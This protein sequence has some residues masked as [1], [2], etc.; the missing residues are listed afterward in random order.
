MNVWFLATM[1]DS[2]ETP[3]NRN[4]ASN[5][6]RKV[7]FQDTSCNFMASCNYRW[8]L[9]KQTTTNHAYW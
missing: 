5:L 7:W 1:L 6:H 3:S 9:M 4:S 8:I 2:C